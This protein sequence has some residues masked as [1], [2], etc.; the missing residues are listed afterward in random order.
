MTSRT[1]LFGMRIKTAGK[2]SSAH[3]STVPPGAFLRE[4]RN[5]S[6]MNEGQWEWNTQR[7]IIVNRETNADVRGEIQK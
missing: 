3:S 5:Y 1:D 2:A 4:V 7:D 6:D